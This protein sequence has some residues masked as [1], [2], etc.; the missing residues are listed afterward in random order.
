MDFFYGGGCAGTGLEIGLIRAI[1]FA[2]YKNPA[3]ILLELKETAALSN[4]DLVGITHNYF[5]AI[6]L[7]VP[8]ESRTLS[9]A[10]TPTIR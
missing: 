2:K 6:P 3:A 1:S 4:G 9:I 7:N 5:L 8:A 10:A